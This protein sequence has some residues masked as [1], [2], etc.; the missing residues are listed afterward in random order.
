M[1]LEIACPIATITSAINWSV[2]TTTLPRGTIGKG[3]RGFE[4]QYTIPQRHSSGYFKIVPLRGK[5]VAE[6]VSGIA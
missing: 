3:E 2:K 6:E 5:F 4:L 1:R